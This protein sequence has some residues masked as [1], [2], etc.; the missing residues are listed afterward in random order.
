VERALLEVAAVSTGH[1][2]PVTDGHSKRSVY[3]TGSGGAAVAEA[4]DEG[5]LPPRW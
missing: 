5:C 2:N 1:D 4:L 3:H